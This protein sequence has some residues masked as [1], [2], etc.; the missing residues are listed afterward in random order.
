MVVKKTMAYILAFALILG[1]CLFMVLGTSYCGD[2]DSYRIYYLDQKIPKYISDEKWQENYCTGIDEYL[3]IEEDNEN[4]GTGWTGVEDGSRW[5]VGNDAYIYFWVE[6][7]ELGYRVQVTA[8]EE[9]ICKN[10]LIVN[11]TDAGELVFDPEEKTASV[12]PDK[13]VFT[14]GINTICIHT[15]EKVRPF[16]ETNDWS[17]DGRRLNL[18]VL[19]VWMDPL[20]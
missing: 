6:E 7:P 3:D 4:L 16:K 2:S 1:Y 19:S 17:T 8:V 5:T 12:T 20:E 15:D 10:R 9:P 13:S 18:N 14:K 11:G